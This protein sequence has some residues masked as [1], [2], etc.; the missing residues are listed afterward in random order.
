MRHR[1]LLACA[2]LATVLSITAC[3]EETTS[4]LRTVTAPAPAGLLVQSARLR[5]NPRPGF[6]DPTVAAAGDSVVVTYLSQGGCGFA[7]EPRAGVSGGTLVITNE[8]R[9]RSEL[10]TLPASG[11]V[12]LRTAA[13]MPTGG[14]YPVVVRERLQTTPDAE[15]F[16]ERQIVRARVTFTR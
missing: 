6:Y 1:P 15:R 5:D 16:A 11:G 9:L 14:T 3:G 13:R 8:W 2:A 4:P 10:C 12:W 7:L